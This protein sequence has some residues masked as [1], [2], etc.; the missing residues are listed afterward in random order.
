[1]GIKKYNYLLCTLFYVTLRVGVGVTT[2]FDRNFPHK[3]V[4]IK[5]QHNIIIKHSMFYGRPLCIGLDVNFLKYNN[6]ML[7]SFFENENK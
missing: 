3:H 6:T 1:M 7:T 2:K 4:Y 5:G